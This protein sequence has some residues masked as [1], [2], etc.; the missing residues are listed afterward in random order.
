MHERGVG[1][2][3]TA[4]RPLPVGVADD[5]GRM[6]GDEGEKDG[7]Q[8]CENETLGKEGKES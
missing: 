2:K 3:G 8:E 7:E 5:G 4:V 6:G 1:R